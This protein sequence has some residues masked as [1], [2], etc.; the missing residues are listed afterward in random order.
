MKIT[1]TYLEE[2]PKAP[3]NHNCL[4]Y[5]YTLKIQT[6]HLDI[7]NMHMYIP[8]LYK[9]AKIFTNYMENFVV[10]PFFKKHS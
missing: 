1:K 7:H 5:Y 3:F 9:F 4:R 2:D 6:I 10:P 8:V